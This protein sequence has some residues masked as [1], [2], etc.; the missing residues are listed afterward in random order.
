[1][2]VTRQSI[3][4]KTTNTRDLPITEE[5]MDAFNRG[6]LAYKAFPN[7]SP[8]DREFIISGITDEEWQKSFPTEEEGMDSIEALST[9]KDDIERVLINIWSRMPMDLPT[10]YDEI[11]QFVFEDV[12]ETADPIEWSEGDVVIGFR[13]WIESKS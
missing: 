4:S 6:E 9:K 10:N 8:A 7:L 11:V 12:C 13:R 3:I 2:L 1:M 5:Q